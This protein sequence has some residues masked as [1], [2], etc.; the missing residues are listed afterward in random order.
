MTG[1]IYQAII[2]ANLS[3]DPFL[4][5]FIPSIMFFFSSIGNIFNIFGVE[6]NNFSSSSVCKL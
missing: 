6:V 5:G 4:L 3:R 2:L 1:L